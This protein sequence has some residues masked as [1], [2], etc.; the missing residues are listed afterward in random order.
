MPGAG[1]RGGGTG[2][3]VSQGQNFRG[4]D[5]KVLEIEVIV[6]QLC[7]ILNATEPYT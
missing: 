3:S 2:L 4:D 7:D 1:G 6:A 5:K